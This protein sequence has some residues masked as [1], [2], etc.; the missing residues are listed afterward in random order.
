MT[1]SSEISETYE[2]ML[3][4][5]H[6]DP[7]L[8]EYGDL[9]ERLD[10]IHR[11][12]DKNE[13]PLRE[14][15]IKPVKGDL[16]VELV[17]AAKRAYEAHWAWDEAGRACNEAGQ[18]CNEA[19]RAYRILYKKHQAAIEALHAKECTDCPWDGKTIFAVES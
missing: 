6:H 17:E 13:W 2:G 3:W 12:K 18:A 16:P 7:F 9:Q 5:Q 1:K 14:R 8:V 15:L 19:E 10:E 11:I 4:H